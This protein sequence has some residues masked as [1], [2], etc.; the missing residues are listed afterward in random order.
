MQLVEN[1]RIVFQGNHKQN[2]SMWSFSQTRWEFLASGMN[3]FEDLTMFFLKKAHFTLPCA[4]FD[5]EKYFLNIKVILINKGYLWSDQDKI[6]YGKLQTWRNLIHK[7]IKALNWK[8]DYPFPHEYIIIIFKKR[9][10]KWIE[11][12]FSPQLIC[13]LNYLESVI[14]RILSFSLFGKEIS[15]SQGVIRFYG[16]MRLN[17]SSIFL[18][19]VLV[20][21]MEKK[22]PPVSNPWKITSTRN[23]AG[24]FRDWHHSLNLS[25][26]SER[27]LEIQTLSSVPKNLYDLI[28]PTA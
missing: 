10:P 23:S 6:M 14:K 28:A 1:S 3:Q 19:Q 5:E 26:G 16:W 18:T 9:R 12:I 2:D 15:D 22:T 11:C 4:F 24:D 25:I 7:K 27:K 17:H 20:R 8:A 21:P 13:Y